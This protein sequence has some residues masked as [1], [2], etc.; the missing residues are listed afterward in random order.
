MFCSM[1]LL[2]TNLTIYQKLNS[3]FFEKKKIIEKSGVNSK[4]VLKINKNNQVCECCE[5]L[6]LDFSFQLVK[7]FNDSFR[8]AFFIFQIE[9]KY[10]R[11]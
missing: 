8:L 6:I 11:L 4:K 1:W 3:F 9:K 5:S 2:Q 10:I 7:N